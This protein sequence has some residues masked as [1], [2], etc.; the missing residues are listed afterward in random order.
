[1][2][3]VSSPAPVSSSCPQ[4]PVAIPISRLPALGQGFTKFSRSSYASP[5]R[6]SPLTG[7]PKFLC[8]TLTPT[9]L[10]VEEVPALSDGV[11]IGIENGVLQG[12]R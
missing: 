4:L 12:A 3:D 5:Q 9:D 2:T 6:L 10:N 8:S 11:Q 7:Y 1:M